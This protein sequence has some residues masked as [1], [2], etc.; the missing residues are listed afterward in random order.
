M[1]RRETYLRHILLGL[2][3]WEGGTI[4]SEVPQHQG[5]AYPN[6]S[7]DRPRNGMTSASWTR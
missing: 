5:R 3:D 7:I 4:R 2:P 6:R 1:L